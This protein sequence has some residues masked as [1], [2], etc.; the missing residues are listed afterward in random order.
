MKVW[1]DDGTFLDPVP[2]SMWKL[3]SVS[4]CGCYLVIFVRQ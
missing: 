2:Y 1:W 4:D 3:H